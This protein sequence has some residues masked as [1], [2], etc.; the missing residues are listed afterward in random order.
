[1]PFPTSRHFRDDAE[2]DIRHNTNWPPRLHDLPERRIRSKGDHSGAFVHGLRTTGSRLLTRR[3]G[4]TAP[5]AAAVR[6]H[7]IR[8][9]RT[10]RAGRCR[11]P[12][13]RTTVRTRPATRFIALAFEEVPCHQSFGRETDHL[14]DDV[15]ILQEPRQGGVRILV[16]PRSPLSY[17]CL[18]SIQDVPL[19]RPHHV[20][21]RRAVR[22]R[23]GRGRPAIG[24]SAR[25]DDGVPFVGTVRAGPVSR[26]TAPRAA[27]LLN[28]AVAF[29]RTIRT[30]TVGRRNAV[31]ALGRHHASSHQ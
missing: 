22:A 2:L 30:G 23:P 29:V 15:A 11:R 8:A 31:R 13:G 17:F 19:Q 27:A 16:I 18:R 20:A 9:G 21:L 24:A 14:S 10:R 12:G 6:G 5:S 25:I 3:D 26:R 28:D 4:I 7:Q 1:M